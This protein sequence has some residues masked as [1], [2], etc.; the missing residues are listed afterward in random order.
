LTLLE[1]KSFY[2]GY[3][4]AYHMHS[5]KDD[6]FVQDIDTIAPHIDGGQSRLTLFIELTLELETPANLIIYAKKSCD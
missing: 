1:R 5:F 4:E 3:F 6:V 2:T